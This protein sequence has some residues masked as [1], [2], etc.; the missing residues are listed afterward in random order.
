MTSLL[1]KKAFVL[2]AGLGDRMR[3]LTDDCPK[4]LLKVGGRTMLDRVLDS[5][6]N[7]GVNEVVVNTFY[8]ASIMEVH[9]RQRKSLKIIISRET[10]LLNTG[11]GVNKM[12]DF[13]G[14]EPFYVLN[15]DVVWTDGKK[16][17]LTTLAE[18]WNSS[19]MDLLLLLYPS[20]NIPSYAGNGDYY[21]AEKSNRPLFAKGNNKAANYVFAGPRIVHPRLFTGAPEG[22]FSFLELF[23]KA[24]R[25]GKLCGLRHDGA[26]YHVGTPEALAETT[27]ILSEK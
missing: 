9:L 5:L 21:M 2:A 19:K 24:E 14:D 26:W 1:P 8:L 23:H 25:D 16:P 4:P 11:G 17:M 10:E 15:A 7:A 13:F 3:P 6:E 20:G 22:A 12:I 18:A 27:Q